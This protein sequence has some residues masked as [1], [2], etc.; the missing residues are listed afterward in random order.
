LDIN[1]KEVNRF[2]FKGFT[3]DSKGNILN[4]IEFN[5]DSSVANKRM[6]RYFENGAVEDYIEYD[7]FDELLERHTYFENGTGVIDKVVYEYEDGHKTI[8]EFHCSDLGF[9]DHVIL[10]DEANLVTGYELYTLNENGQVVEEIETDS[11]NIEISKYVKT[12]NQEG[13]LL[14]D[15]HFIEG[16]LT[17][18][19]AYTY[20]ERNNLIKKGVTNHVDHLMVTESYI[21]DSRDNMV[22]NT[23][24]QNDVLVFEN[25]CNYDEGNNL[26]DE[27]FFEISYREKRIIRHE[28]LIHER[29]IELGKVLGPQILL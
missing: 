2:L 29:R 5:A 6:Y 14:H 17:E 19:N 9:T 27:E 24:F 26:I 22:L 3:V 8:K 1:K 7:P 16:K 15:K 23:G 20:D 28:R 13:L 11:N 4:E 21:Y 25:K 18:S 10:K 12:Y